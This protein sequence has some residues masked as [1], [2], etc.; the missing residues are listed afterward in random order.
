MAYAILL[1]TLY[2][3]IMILLIALIFRGVTFEFRFKGIKV[4]LV[5]ILLL[6]LVQY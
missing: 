6:Q 1:P 5:G 3:S 2:L 4:S